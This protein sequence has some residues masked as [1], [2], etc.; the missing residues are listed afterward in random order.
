MKYHTRSK[1][2][3]ASN[4]SF[5]ADTLKAYS[6]AW[7]RFVDV[8]NG[9]VVFNNYTYS[10]T[11]NR[12]QSKVRSLMRTLGIAIDVTIECPAGLQ[13]HDWIESTVKHYQYK[14]DTLRQLIAN[15]KSRKTTNDARRVAIASYSECILTVKQLAS[16]IAA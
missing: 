5:N 8:V 1:E 4:V 6:Y 14:I 13:A 11:T 10:M 3:R 9:K 16:K 7:W 15:P 12:H 2:W